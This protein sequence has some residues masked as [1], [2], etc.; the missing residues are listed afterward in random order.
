T[1]EERDTLEDVVEP[2]LMQEGF[3]ERT[4]RGRKATPAAFKHLGMAHEGD[5][6][7]RGGS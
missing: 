2:Y 3:L 5:L 6:F 4:P 1:G 7:Q